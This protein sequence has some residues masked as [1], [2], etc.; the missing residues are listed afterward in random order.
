MRGNNTA[1]NA[2]ITNLTKNT[3]IQY[4]IL[5]SDTQS[6]P[7]SGTKHKLLHTNN[8]VSSKNNHTNH[9]YHTV[10]HKQLSNTYQALQYPPLD[11]NIILFSKP[12][13]T[14]CTLPESTY[15]NH[16][17]TYTDT[18]NSNQLQYHISDT[19]ILT[20]STLKIFKTKKI[21]L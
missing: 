16:H 15:T 17:T 10:Y 14:R 2:Y 8:Y 18:T 19:N 5:P 1:K 21:E 11:N 12:H 3:E 7:N 9:F 4:I 20:Q 13:N 6:L